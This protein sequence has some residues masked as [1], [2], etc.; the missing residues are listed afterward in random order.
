MC[1]VFLQPRLVVSLVAHVALP[2]ARVYAVDLSVGA[3]LRLDGGDVA[4]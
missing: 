2:V 4:Q 3:P 1:V